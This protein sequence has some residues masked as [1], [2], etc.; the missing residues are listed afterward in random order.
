MLDEQGIFF[1]TKAVLEQKTIKCPTPVFDQITKANSTVILAIHHGETNVTIGSYP[2]KLINCSNFQS[3]A[4]CTSS[5]NLCLWNRKISQCRSQPKEHIFFTH[6]LTA[7]NQCPLIYLQPSR[8][9]LAY[10]VDK[11]LII[12]IEQCNR[13]IS[14]QS[15][16]L[17]DHRKRFSLTVSNP[18]LIPSDNQSTSCLL[19]C[20][21]QWIDTPQISFHRPINLR[22][23][24]EF[25][26]QTIAIIPNSQISLYQ[27]E[28]LASNCS[29]CLQLNPSYGCAWCN[30]QCIY[31]NHS[32]KCVDQQHRCLTPL[33]EKI[34]PLILPVHGGTLV[35]IMGRHFDR[36][37]LTVHL[38]NVP[39]QVV[40]EESSENK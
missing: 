18:I 35:T 22:L 29:S 38:A 19:K 10:H 9:H 32:N 26:N 30:N 8:T 7:P 37:K 5:S 31:K 6:Y 16:R 13:S 34:E 23:S 3:C 17:N 2:L 28:H 25:S 33:I 24:I 4:S 1:E 14:I 20:F 40:E 27:C 15:C 39:C 36:S 21:F 12:H 11:T